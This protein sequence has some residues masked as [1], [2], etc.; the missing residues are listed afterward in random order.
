MMYI[1]VYTYVAVCAI[2]NF[3]PVLAERDSHIFKSQTI[4]C[5]TSTARKQGKQDKR[6]TPLHSVFGIVSQTCITSQSL[7]ISLKTGLDGAGFISHRRLE[8][9]WQINHGSAWIICSLVLH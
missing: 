5:R 1:Y 8:P 6:C 4:C 9:R 2:S 3:V 7:K